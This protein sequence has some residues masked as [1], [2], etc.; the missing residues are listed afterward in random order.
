MRVLI[1]AE[2]LRRAVPGGIGTY[3]RGLL[4]G[5]AAPG[6]AGSVEVTLLASGPV[7]GSDLPVRTSVLPAP[8]LTRLWDRGV[9]R[10]PDGYDVVHAPSLLTVPSTAPVSVTVHDVAWRDVPEAFPARGRRWHEAALT[11]AMQR[12]STVIVPSHETAA[13]LAAVACR[14]GRVH[15]VEEGCDHLPPPDRQGAAELLGRL[16]V[17][18]PYLLTVST[19][20]PRKNLARLVAAYRAARAALPEPWPLVVVGPSGWGPALAP[21]AGVVLAGFVDEAVKAALLADA[22]LLVYVPLVEGFGLPAVEA[23]AM[24]TPV[25][26]SPMP[27]T[28]G[29]ALTIDPTDVEAMADALVRAATDDVVRARLLSAGG[30]RAAA[31]TW[32]AAARGHV[33]LWRAGA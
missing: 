19:I 14:D 21:A 11:R 30:R 28:G 6:L 12:A 27:S 31:L 29:A 18:P 23:M 7:P 17:R 25:V 1:V 5:L 24:G 20:E 26:A 22:R 15:V 3:V 32:E 4:Q 10:A 2:Q 9:L 33:D 16:G 8:V 13:A